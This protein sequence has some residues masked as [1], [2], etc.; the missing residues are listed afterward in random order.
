MI[1]LIHQAKLF[2]DNH[3][4]DYKDWVIGSFVKN[5]TFNTDKFEFKF[6]RGATGTFR[7]PKE[8]LNPNTTT[9]CI[10][11]YG[12]VRMKFINT[13][14]EHYIENEGD[15]VIWSPDEPHEFEFM[16]DTLVITLRWRDENEINARV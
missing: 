13:D 1:R 8:V 9:I 12:K 3:P 6:Q 11:V 7:R 16:E 10:L 5:K 2:T 14:V 4:N 15:Y